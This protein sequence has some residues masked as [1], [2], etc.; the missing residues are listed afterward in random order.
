MSAVYTVT[1]L[2]AEMLAPSMYTVPAGE[3]SSMTFLGKGIAKTIQGAIREAKKAFKADENR[4]RDE[5]REKY[6][7][8]NAT[9]IYGH[10][11]VKKNGKVII[12]RY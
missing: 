2:E 9:P 1:I 6:G 7:W 5:Y 8:D 11:I 10:F 3:P 4:V 12:E